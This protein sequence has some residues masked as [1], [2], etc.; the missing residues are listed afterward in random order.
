MIDTYVTNDLAIIGMSCRFPGAKNLEEFWHNLKNGVE[1]ISFFSEQELEEKPKPEIQNHPHFVKASAVLDDVE[2]FDASFFDFSPREAELTDPQHRIFLESAWEAIEQAGY[3]PDRYEGRIGVYAGA[4]LNTYLLFNL[5]PELLRKE[6][7]KVLIANDKDYLATRTSYKLN[8]TGPSINVQTACSTSL[9]AIGLACQSLLDYQCDIALAG[10]VSIKV[11]QKSGYWY[12]E[13]GILSPDGHCRAFDA[14]ARGTVGGNGVGVVVLKRLA[15]AIADGDYIH[16]VIKGAAINNDGAAKVGYTAP[17]VDGQAEA[18]AEALAMAGV[19]PETIGYVEAHG[20]GTSLGDP[21]EIA[22][23]KK[24]FHASTQKQGYCAIGSLKTNVGHMNA[25]AG[26]GSLIKTVLALQHKLLPPSLHFE[27]LNPQ[28]DASSP[29]YVNN[30]L[31][32]WKANGTP[33]RAGVSSFGVGGTNAHAILEEAPVMSRQQEQGRKYQLLVLSAKTDSALEA[34]TVNLVDRLKQHPDL[35]LADVAYTLQVGRKAFD[36]RRVGVVKDLDDAIKVLELN[37]P[38]RVFTKSQASKDRNIRKE[39]PVVFMFTGQG[40]QY[41]NMTRELYDNEPTFREQIDR[42]CQQLEPYLGL[43]LRQVLYPGDE[44]LETARATLEQT[45]ITQPALFAI[46]YAL[47]K[48]W[49]SWGVQPVA[50]IGHSIGEYVAACIAGVFSLEDALELVAVRGRLMQQQP[51]GAMLSVPLSA[52]EVK[53]LLVETFHETSLQL[54]ASNAPNLSVVSGSFTAIE[55]LE[56][57]LQQQGINSRRLHTSHAFHSQM[58]DSIIEPFTQQVQKIH[59]QPPQIPFIS[60]VTGSWITAAEAT[61]PNYWAKH[62]RQPVRFSEG[63]T[64]LLKQ[65]KQIFLEVGPGNTL[66]TLVRQHSSQLA[67][68]VVLSCVRHPKSQESDL[69]FLLNTLGQLWLAGVTIDWSGFYAWEQRHRLPLPTYPFERQRYW[70]EPPEQLSAASNGKV[71]TGRKPDITDWFYIPSWKRSLPP[72]P[73]PPGE[74]A[75]KCWLVFVDECGL[76]ERIVKRLQLEGRE[77]I[78][79]LVGEEFRRI[80]DRVCT[81]NPATRADYQALLAE[82]GDRDRQP[83]VI[84]HLWNIT[85]SDRP[86]EKAQVFSYDSLVY[87]AQALGAREIKHSVQIQVVS[88]NLQGVWGSELLYPEKATILGLCRVIPQEYAQIACRS[89]DIVLPEAGKP[90]EK[91]TEQLIAEFAANSSDIAIAYRETHRWVEAFEPVKLE[92]TVAKKTRLQQGGVYLLTGGLGGMSL[93][94]AEYLAKTVQPKLVLLGR[95]VFPHRDEWKQ[96]LASHEATDEISCKI[97]R[98]QAIE[99]L[100]AEV[101]VLSAD[102]ANLA[103][104]QD[105]IASSTERFGQIQGVFHTAGVYGGGLIQLKTPETADGNLVPKVQGTKVLDLVLKDTHLDFFIL[106]SSIASIRGQVGYADYC[107][108]NSFLDAFAHYKSLRDNTF[109]ASINWENWQ[110]VGMSIAVEARQKALTGKEWQQGMT[111][112]EG[113]DALSRILGCQLSQA[114]VSTHE[115]QTQIQQD[116]TWTLPP[117]QTV[118][119]CDRESKFHPRPTLSNTY[120]SPRD[121]IE[122]AIADIW[123]ETLGIDSIGIYDD[124]FELGGDSLVALPMVAQLRDT[125]QVELPL[126]TL[127]NK[128]NVAA[129]AQVI[130]D[131]E[132]KPGQTAKIARTLK[133]VKE[134]STQQVREELDVKQKGGRV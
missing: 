112:S 30:H 2:L 8:L 28:I 26:V 79:V 124:F 53:S 55:Q 123:Q 62:L 120:V 45:A 61:D 58:M 73:L 71:T 97:R 18:I 63:I 126:P 114:I 44:Q 36:R 19:E 90:V 89:I 57:Q 99:N 11:P 116:R 10:G 54:A 88:N 68:Q 1:S 65:S 17:S 40:S 23:L 94:I 24:V 50:A 117:L 133:R 81:I 106:F 20:T 115:L 121:E 93:V 74:L 35:N 21:I 60:N 92:S 59:L 15:E 56:R 67:G 125:F 52:S 131:N 91:L 83:Q 47:A 43:D 109:T 7:L 5:S 119:D 128:A 14:K 113:L 95:S 69:A 6:F 32:E 111:S 98:L 34:A 104:M 12:E 84:A 134:M 101:L 38:Q 48:L 132:A 37:D 29:F 72:E 77:A 22:A 75:G 39:H 87:L 102:V 9:V 118:A 13:G 82:L 80:S 130:I 85:P 49:N 122:Q 105:A 107:A 42:C 100:G 41:P 46:E 108:A 33:R 78:A 70:I 25:A 96:W 76:G 129:L 51:Q 127:F 103:Q 110:S 3:V 66:S 31:S 16:A 64:E 86:L 4:G 27:V